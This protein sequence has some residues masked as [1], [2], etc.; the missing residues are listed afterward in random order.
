MHRE[1]DM[2]KKIEL[3]SILSPSQQRARD[4]RM[5]AY[6]AGITVHVVRNLVTVK[7]VK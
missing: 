1:Y 5:A 3:V 2:M 7:G 6:A 4:L